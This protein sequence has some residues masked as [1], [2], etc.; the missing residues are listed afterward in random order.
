MLIFLTICKK[1]DFE[2]LSERH[3]CVCRSIQRARGLNNDSEEGV[4]A[5]WRITSISNA[6]CGDGIHRLT[7]PSVWLR[8]NQVHQ[9][10]QSMVLREER[11]QQDE[12]V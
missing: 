3:R 8:Q 2:E 9:C 6:W 11:P 12:D 10:D 7:T 1:N 4:A 5:C